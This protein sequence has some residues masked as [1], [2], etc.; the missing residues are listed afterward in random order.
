VRILYKVYLLKIYLKNLHENKFKHYSST[1]SEIAQYTVYGN[2][3][4]TSRHLNTAGSVVISID[5]DRVLQVFAA[6]RSTRQTAL[7]T[8]ASCFAKS[9][10]AASSALRATASVAELAACPW[11]KANIFKR[12][13]SECIC[14]PTILIPTPSSFLIPE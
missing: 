5:D 1:Y 3:Y 9:A 2:Q 10:T 13:T 4:F 6:N 8:R 12:R 7:S 11:T 14:R